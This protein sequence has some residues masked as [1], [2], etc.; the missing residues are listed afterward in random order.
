MK[1]LCL[2]GRSL[3][4]S[5]VVLAS[6]LFFSER[7]FAQVQVKVNDTINLKLGILVQGQADWTENAATGAYAQ[8]LF[9]RRAR[10]LMGGQI[11]PNLSFFY[12]TDNPNLGKATTNAT[13][14]S[15]NNKTISTGLITQ[16]A[17]LTWKI[18]DP[19]GF[20][21]GLMFIPF[22][23][24][25]IQSAASLLPID[26]G[27]Y[28][29]TASAPTQSVVGRDTGV[30]A[31]GYVLGNHLEYRLG[32]F[33]GNRSA[34]N[35]PLRVAG[36]VQYNFLDPESMGFFYT[37]T[38]LGAKKVLTLG[39]GV[40]AQKE[41]RAYAVDLFVDHPVG[42]GSVTAQIDYLSFDGDP[43][44]PALPKQRDWLA[45]AGYYLPQA[46]LMPWLKLEGRQVKG[47]SSQNEQRYQLGLTYYV[48]AHNVNLKAGV[49]R[50]HTEPS[51][52]GN[53]FTVQLQGFYF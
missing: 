39:A 3:I 45:E 33:Q 27:A 34:V 52:N 15:P 2:Q 46:K 19:L 50:V 9:L 14:A 42:P 16:D 5:F 30:Q 12:Q 20:D 17:F 43:T 6:S 28:T 40:D 22:C 10:F 29:F 11:A 38:Y 23:R 32:A 8:N 53:L 26:Y 21:I 1:R 35:N 4:L 47:A 48:M 36:R 49:G 41:Y 44:A 31:R 7:A 24:N 51:G 18:S 25:C 13:A 37:G